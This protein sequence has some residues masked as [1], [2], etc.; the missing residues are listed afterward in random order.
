MEC[1]IH[2]C[3]ME[4]VESPDPMGEGY[5]GYWFCEECRLDEEADFDAEHSDF[6]DPEIE[7]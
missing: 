1:E 3:E 2:G 6:E 4:W 5:Y 7:Y